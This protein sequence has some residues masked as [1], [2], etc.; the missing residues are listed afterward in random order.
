MRQNEVTVKKPSGKGMKTRIKNAASALIVSGIALSNNAITVFAA[1]ASQNGGA[2]ITDN[3]FATKMLS[4]AWWAIIAVIGVFAGMG[5]IKLL[6]AQSEEDPR[7]RNNG[8]VTLVIS[9]ICLV[10]A[11]AF[12][13]VTGA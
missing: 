7:G 8:I 13:T 3:A 9:G 2:G 1:E 11:I 4:F 5:V 10:A 6:Q 12:K